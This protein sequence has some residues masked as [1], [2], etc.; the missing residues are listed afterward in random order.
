MERVHGDACYPEQATCTYAA[1]TLALKRPS[2]ICPDPDALAQV[3]SRVGLELNG[4]PQMWTAALA[5][6]YLRS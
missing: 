3:A 5:I 2:N 1:D 4:R 6:P